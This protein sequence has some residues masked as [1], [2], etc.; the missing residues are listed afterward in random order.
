MGAVPDKTLTITDFTFEKGNADDLIYM[1]EFTK[2]GQYFY[3]YYVIPAKSSGLY[4]KDG[5]EFQGK[6]L[7]YRHDGAGNILFMITQ[8]AKWISLEGRIIHSDPV[9]MNVEWMP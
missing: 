2:E 8:E 9:G 5:L 3:D 7:A 4:Q 1:A 6:F